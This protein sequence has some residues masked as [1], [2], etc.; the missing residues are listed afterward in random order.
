[1]A[2]KAP[3]PLV[4]RV[5][6]GDIVDVR[7]SVV[8]VSHFNGL[9]PSGA[10]AAVDDAL[11]GALS[12]R[13]L[14][15]H[16]GAATYLPARGSRIAADGVLV[17]CLGEVEKLTEAR[18]PELGYALVDALAAFGLADAAT[19]IHGAKALASHPAKLTRPLL[20]GIYEA[21]G[22]LPGAERIHELTIVDVDPARLADIG[23]AI[24]EARAPARVHLYLE[25]EVIPTMPAR[26][27]PPVVAGMPGHLRIGLQRAGPILK[28]TVADGEDAIR[29]DQADWPE[30]V[31]RNIINRLDTEVLRQK[32]PAQSADALRAIGVQL[33]TAFLDWANLDIRER[34]ERTRGDY[35]VL[36]CDQMTVRLPWELLQDGHDFLSR[37]HRLSRQ[38]EIGGAGRS[39]AWPPDDGRLKVLIVVDPQQNLPGAAAEGEAIAE[40]LGALSGT[41][42]KLLGPG[43]RWQELSQALNDDWDVLHFA[44]HA[45]YDEERHGASGLI[46][47]DGTLTADDLSTRR[48][49]P[50]L[51]VANACQSAKSDGD[52]FDGAP[53]TRDL[54]A[55][56]LSAGARAVVGSMWK[57]GDKPA[58]T[59][60]KAFYV[61]LAPTGDG[62]APT[63]GMAMAEARDAVA[64]EHPDDPAWGGYALYGSPWKPALTT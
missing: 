6:Q 24:G 52:L 21:L 57:V 63:I 26:H 12:R 8:V 62:V 9:A 20:E 28:V 56:L 44:G 34:L 61:A 39:A 32:D 54:V 17:L 37:S 53:P 11:G 43:V 27:P 41:D 64:R 22:R 33:Y 30:E 19:V 25:P 10:E 59:F 36:G 23:A 51:V 49:L 31:E 14:D 1:V 48:Y 16:L 50:R 15:G 4:V 58:A 29:S 42:V 5:A 7:A 40:T 2:G 38:L 3:S 45:S 60:G 46:L 55:G 13:S 18:L 47:A 35:V